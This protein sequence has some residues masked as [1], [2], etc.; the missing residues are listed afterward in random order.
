MSDIYPD[1]RSS[2]RGTCFGS[3]SLQTALYLGLKGKHSRLR[4]YNIVNAY[5]CIFIVSPT[6]ASALLHGL[7]SLRLLKLG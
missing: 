4:L 7:N 2:A 6:Q 1:P 3:Y 5:F